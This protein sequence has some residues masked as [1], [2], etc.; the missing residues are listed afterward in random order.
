MGVM[1]ISDKLHE[2]IETRL[3]VQAYLQDLRYALENG[4][5]LRVQFTRHV[6]QFRDRK[7][8]NEYAFAELFPQKNI[9]KVLIKE[10]LSLKVDNYIRTVADINR[11]NNSEMREFGKV[12][13]Q[14]KEVYIKIRVEIMKSGGFGVNHV[15]FVMSFHYSTIPFGELEFP[16]K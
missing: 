1:N 5:K 4:A 13:D 12:Y 7:Y 15:V 6:E 10:L 2:R 9:E 11:P 14:D 16:Y 8:S 3:E